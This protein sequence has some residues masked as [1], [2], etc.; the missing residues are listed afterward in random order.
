[1]VFKNVIYLRI[2]ILYFKMRQI[3]S[4]DLK[5]MKTLDDTEV[6][7]RL[8]IHSIYNTLNVNF[9]FLPFKFLILHQNVL[10]KTT[11]LET[12]EMSI[13]LVKYRSRY[14]T[15]KSLLLVKNVRIFT[16]IKLISFLRDIVNI[17]YVLRTSKETELYCHGYSH[18]N[19]QRIRLHDFAGLPLIFR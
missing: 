1:M 18:E 6:W 17:V 2:V 5:D 14:P 13:K 10:S 15:T 8:L 16:H 7:F 19:E 12:L 11:E 3:A 4:V 9:I